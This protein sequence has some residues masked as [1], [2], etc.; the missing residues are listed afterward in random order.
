MVA[1]CTPCDV[2]VT[3]SFSGHSVASIRLRNS[4]S[5]ASGISIW[6]GRIAFESSLSIAGPLS[7]TAGITAAARASEVRIFRALGVWSPAALEVNVIS[8]LV[9]ISLVRLNFRLQKASRFFRGARCNSICLFTNN[10]ENSERNGQQ[11]F[12]LSTRKKRAE[13]K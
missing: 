10:S 11:E 7:A 13:G 3:V 2:S 5:F 12:G 8:L 6:K 9:F 1:N 4:A